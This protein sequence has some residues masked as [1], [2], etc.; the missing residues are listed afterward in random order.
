MKDTIYT[1]YLI[2]CIVIA[3]VSF[4]GGSAYFTRR[5]NDNFDKKYNADKAERDAAKKEADERE[6]ARIDQQI[7]M[8][9]QIVAAGYLAKETAEA[10]IAKC[11]PNKKIETA[12]GTYADCRSRSE[13]QLRKS[14]AKY[15]QRAERPA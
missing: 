11:G 13:N 12:L 10:H 4:F 6:Q 3:I 2:I 5:V 15:E 1:V 14:A 9:E 8:Q 7:L